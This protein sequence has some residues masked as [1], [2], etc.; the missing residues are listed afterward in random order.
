MKHMILAALIVTLS[1]SAPASGSSMK[2]VGTGEALYMGFITVYDAALYT[3]DPA[4]ALEI[5]S[6]DVSK[7]LE[8][9]YRVSLKPKDF[10][11][12]ARVVLE[13]Q[14][15]TE[16][17]DVVRSE[18]DRLHRAYVQVEKGDSYRLCYDAA[19]AATTLALNGKELVSITSRLFGTYYLGIW[20]G[21]EKPLST[22]LRKS[23]LEDG[24]NG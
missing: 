23:L 24:T 2:L 6:P 4:D 13:R 20:L 21:P 15:S 9:T 12:G 8:L 5:L 22:S 11:K 14:H 7:C 10:I 1:V 18:I 16:E 19:T 17:I 3:D